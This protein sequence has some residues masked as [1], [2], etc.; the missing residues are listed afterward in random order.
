VQASWALLREAQAAALALPNT[1]QAVAIDVGDPNDIHPRDKQPV[2]HRLAL[3]ARRVVYGEQLTAAGPAYR[4]HSTGNGR[5]T[6][7]FDHGGAGLASRTGGQTVN[8]FAIAG[9]DRRWAW[10]D[11]RIDGNRVVVSSP[12]VPNPV[13]ARYAWAN[14]PATPGLTNREGLPAAPFRTDDW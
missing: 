2:A 10:A 7:E 11:A 1:G 4:S 14:S 13:A 8:G 9:E 12:Q 5:I 6:I 3:A